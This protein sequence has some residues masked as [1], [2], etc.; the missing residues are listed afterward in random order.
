M[1]PVSGDSLEWQCCILKLGGLTVLLDCGWTEALDP[2]LLAGLI[3]H[4]GEVD[5]IL[6]S[7]SGVEY[8]GAVPYLLTR[9][10]VDCPILC[11]EPVK[12]LGELSCVACLEDHDK[13]RTPA[14]VYDVDDVLRVFVSRVTSV[15]YRE[16]L[17]LHV[18]G[19]NLTVCPLPAGGELGAA[20]WTLQYGGVSA[21]YLVGAELRR[22][23]YLDG[24]DLR[25][26]LRMGRGAAPRWDVLVTAP[27]APA[28]PA[29]VAAQ[30]R[31]RGATQPPQEVQSTVACSA[32]SR[33][34]A[35]AGSVREQHLLEE[36]ISTLRRGG[37]V[38]IPCDV[39]SWLPE[40][41]LLLEAAWAQDRQ[42]ATNYPLVW[43]SS[44]GDMLLDQVR[45]RLEYMSHE[46]LADFEARFGHNPFTL[47]HVRIFQTLEDLC[48]AHPL[49][50]PKVI[51]SSAV[52]HRE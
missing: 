25:P 6:L 8:L 39:T 48:A 1:I 31:Q 42:L 20:Y 23:R 29:P 44:T 14:D 50:R 3:P 27:A 26:L 10:Q 24:A 18:R 41:L 40:V 43:L 7:H 33:S 35:V 28:A 49:S 16:S 52:A 30:L 36:T 32:S 9:Y 51:L 17:H 15:S 46:V 11:T 19:R 12:R 2:K 34:L 37:I 4:L 13:Y 45:T 47:R 22:G 5:L 21:V 38:L